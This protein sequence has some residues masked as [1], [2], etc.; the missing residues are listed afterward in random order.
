MPSTRG[1]Q[2]AETQRRLSADYADCVARR[3]R[4]ARRRFAAARGSERAET[5]AHSRYSACVSVRS[6]TRVDDR[7]RRPSGDARHLC[8][9][10][11]LWL[12]DL[13]VLRSL[14]VVVDPR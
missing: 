4:I 1:N 2:A 11:S 13:C 3:P 12:I 5:Q 7:L 8:V 14:R 6:L 9:S 10:V